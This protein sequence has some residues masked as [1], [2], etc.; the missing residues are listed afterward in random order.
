VVKSDVGCLDDDPNNVAFI[1]MTAT[2]GGQD[3]VEE[4]VACKMYPLAYGFS[5]KDV[6]VGTIPVMKVRTPLLVFPVGI[7]SVEGASHLL[8]EIETEAERMLGSIRL[9]EYG[10]CRW[11]TSLIVAA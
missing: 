9:K 1:H 4:F 2:I 6:V 7:V 8:A 10:H 5:F 11:R 3:A